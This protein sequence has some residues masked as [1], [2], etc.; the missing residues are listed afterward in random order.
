MALN[1]FEIIS[2]ISDI[3]IIA[4][5]DAVRERHRLNRVYA[6]SRLTRWRKLKG[7][8]WV[9]YPNGVESWAEIHWFEAHGIG[10]REE[11]VKREIRK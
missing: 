6:N 8:A 9:R 5:G 7:Y 11:K 4:A 10:R 1:R 2:E 3:E